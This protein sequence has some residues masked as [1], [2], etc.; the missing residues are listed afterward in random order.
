[1]FSNARRRTRAA[2]IAGISASVVL[3]GGAL[4][5]AVA[6]AGT[7][8]ASTTAVPWA[9][10]GPGWVLDMYSKAPGTKTTPTTLYLVSPAGA[11]YAL[12]T[13][14]ASEP[15][16]E[17][18]AWAGSKTEALFQLV[19]AKT[20]PIAEWA[21]MNLRTGKTTDVTFGKASPIGFT[22]PTGQ[23]VLGAYAGGGS[24][25]IARYTQAGA[26][27]KK[28]VTENIKYLGG[29]GTP[30]SLYSADG[31]ELAVGAANGVQLVSNAGGVLK[32][33]PVPGADTR[34]GCS[35]V[36][37]WTRSTLLVECMPKTG[38][39]PQL[40]LAPA[41]GARPVALTP[42]R[43]SGFDLGDIGAWKLSSGLYLQSLGACGTLEINKQAK[44][45]SVTRVTV[46]GAA[47]SPVVI[48]ATTA[49]L[50]VWQ[51][52]CDGLGGQ[53]VW[54]NPATRAEKWLTKTGSLQVIA[55]NAA[56]NAG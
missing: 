9:S 22:R 46:P 33:L 8:A 36:R 48:T 49:Q 50:L 27:M 26:L 5:T 11:K 14:K 6:A 21:E 34:F 12:H 1:M 2:V 45:G 31:T 41:N 40:W 30:P 19:S 28:L 42:A 53:L 3:G 37:W 38:F 25:T 56:E 13:W 7:Q 52:G 16:P 18:M 55:Y 4:G 39:E 10:V 15:A 24:A 35:P 29:F 51:R 43:K 54:F 23:Q 20:G 17:L 44:N 32:K 47:D